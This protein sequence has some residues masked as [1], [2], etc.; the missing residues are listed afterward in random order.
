MTTHKTIEALA[1][2]LLVTVTAAHGAVVD[3]IVLRVNDRIAT[4]SEYE[5]RVSERIA[6]I[7]QSEVASAER[8]EL[9]EQAPRHVLREIADELL[10]L[11]RADQLGIEP[12]RTQVEQA[13]A[14]VR[15]GFGLASEAELV[16]ALQ[17]AGLDL[18]A[19]REQIRSNLRYQAVLS[20]EVYGQIQV[21]EDE[22]LR[23]YREHADE[24]RVPAR[25]ELQ[26]L[27][28]LEEAAASP[29]ELEAI[30]GRLYEELAAGRTLAALAEEDSEEG[31]TSGLI[32]LGWV[33]PGD[34]A[35]ALEEAVW[36]L[37]PG[38][39]TPPVRGRGGFH[40]LQVVDRREAGI[41]PYDEVRAQILA[42][43]REELFRDRMESY[44][45]RLERTAYIVAHPPPEAE[46]FL[47]T[48]TEPPGDVPDFEESTPGVD[49]PP[50]D[51]PPP[52]PGAG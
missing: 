4:L 27:V 30:A 37:E 1:L 13:L 48:E 33:G 52:P 8:Q 26:A 39:H 14:E 20:R 41:L 3:R 49:E 51:E 22:L 21:E 12:S 38:Q 45:E 29:E 11:S 9:I 19:F 6:A 2:A 18:D 10:I 35:P 50:A 46:G 28:V 25:L 31:T 5:H 34:L 15:E 40:L 43:E 24:F 32:E 36:D 44:L 16:R 23:H 7:R 47:E 17:Q 42:R